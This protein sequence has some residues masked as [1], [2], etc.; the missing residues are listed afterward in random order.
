MTVRCLYDFRKRSVGRIAAA[1]NQ[2][3][4]AFVE[5]GDRVRIWDLESYDAKTVLYHKIVCFQGEAVLSKG[6][7]A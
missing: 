6:S 4:V 5:G 3:Y 1:E 2:N 7:K